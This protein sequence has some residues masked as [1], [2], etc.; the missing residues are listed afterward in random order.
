MG[1]SIQSRIEAAK[2]PASSLNLPNCDPHIGTNI[3]FNSSSLSFLTMIS[4]HE[5]PLSTEHL[6]IAAVT[7]GVALVSAYFLLCKHNLKLPPIAKESKF[8]TLSIFV[9]CKDAPN[10]LVA[11]MKEL[12]DVFRIPMLDPVHYVII[13]DAAFARQ[14]L[15][16]EE[17]KP[18]MFGRINAVTGYHHNIISSPTGSDTWRN[19][20]K[21]VAPSFSMTNITASLGK[22]NEKIDKLTKIFLQY[23]K[24]KEI[25]DIARLLQQ[26]SMD[27]LCT[28]TSAK[29]PS[30]LI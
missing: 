22:M 26:F 11:K 21:A 14:I 24:D 29:M 4:L 17:E 16:T 1:S 9:G 6:L 25:F 30:R 15:L 10:Y 20:R 18:S 2:S 8:E 7:F 3:Y 28:G 19:A 27:F 23:E 13:C 5:S 12:G